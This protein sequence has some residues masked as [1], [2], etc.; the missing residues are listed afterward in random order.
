MISLQECESHIGY[1]AMQIVTNADQKSGQFKQQCQKKVY[2]NTRAYLL[3][4]PGG[5]DQQG[6]KQRISNL[7]EHHYLD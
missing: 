5:D 3:A 4:R 7:G 2:D 1:Q 6:V